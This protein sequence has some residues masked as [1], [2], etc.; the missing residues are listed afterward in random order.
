[1]I[2][3]DIFVVHVVKQSVIK[4]L[5]NHSIT[6]RRQDSLRMRLG[7]PVII[8]SAVHV[9]SQ[10]DYVADV[11]LWIEDMKVVGIEMRGRPLITIQEEQLELLLSF[12]FSP[13]SISNILQVSAKT[14]YFRVR[15][16]R[17][18]QIFYT[19]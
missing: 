12:G 18:A 7:S 15:I 9:Y 14:V 10:L 6:C 3:N 11:Y 2:L 1:M 4:K 17:N 19:G 5:L 8:I 13:H 16:T